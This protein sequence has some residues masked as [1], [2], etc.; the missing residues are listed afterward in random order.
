[1][2]SLR[3]ALNAIVKCNISAIVYKHFSKASKQN[4]HYK[5]DHVKVICYTVVMND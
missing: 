1:M 2:P 4:T 5:L 3:P